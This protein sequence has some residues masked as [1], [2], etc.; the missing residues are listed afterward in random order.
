MTTPAT[1]G[2]TP[3]SPLV[4]V[5]F[6]YAALLALGGFRPDDSVIVVEEPDVV[7]KRGLRDRAR[8]VPVIRELIEWPYQLDGSADRFYAAH[9]GLSPAAIGP[10]GEYATYFAARL[11]EHYGLPGIGSDVARR[12]RDKSLLRETAR[13]AGIA[14]PASRAVGGPAELAAF[15]ADHPGPVVLKPADLQGSIGARVLD[16]PD[17]AADAWAASVAEC[18][19]QRDGVWVP[20]REV[21]VRM[22]A[23]RCVSGRPFSVELLV[24]SGRVLFGNVTE[25][26]MF[27]GPRPVERGQLVPADIPP[28]LD[29]RL[30]E[31]TEWLV[32]MTGFGTGV[33]HCEWIVEDGTPYLI[34]CAG[35]LPGDNIVDLIE[36]AYDIELVRAY[37]TLLTG[38][39]R[40]PPLPR[41]ARRSAA[42]RYAHATPGTVEHVGGVR[43]AY[44]VPDVIRCEV[45]VRPGSRVG[46]LRSSLDRSA[47]ALACAPTPAQAVRRA[48]EA[49]ARLTVTTRPYGSPDRSPR[50]R[51]PTTTTLPEG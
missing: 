6:S 17:E 34:E 50:H 2:T 15:M 47:F 23:E 42:V 20:D 27:P 41:R 16:S 45:L 1:S 44:A 37:W 36:W 12:L 22:L 4:L 14:N 38:D 40:T 43:E 46:P 8:A 5:G 33:V 32:A 48:E 9:P 31:Q 18:A 11:A 21:P 29:A 49:V 25:E 30:R 7:R 19:A 26:V 24:S 10:A 51:T 3:P 13:A 39:P 35:R 28:A